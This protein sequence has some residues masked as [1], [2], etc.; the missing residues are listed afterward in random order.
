M[1]FLKDKLFSAIKAKPK[2]RDRQ[3]DIA[4]LLENFPSS[5][6]FAESYRT[7]R[8]NLFFTAIEKELK[9]V[10]V[11]SSVEGEGKTTT[12]INLAHTIAQT[13]KKVLLMDADWRRPHLSSLYGLR[14]ENGLSSIVGETYGTHLSQ[15]T[16]SDFSVNDLIQ[17]TKLQ[18]RTCCLNLKNDDTDI[19]F[20]FAKGCM[21]DIFWKN[22]S[23]DKNKRLINILIGDKL[24]TEKEANI[25]LGHLK[26]S[27][28]HL[29]TILYSMG[30]VS[31][32]D[33][34][35]ALSMY[36]I[37]AVK[38]A[39][40]METGTF[41]F[42]SQ[43]T[44]EFTKSS[45]LNV[46]FDK[47]YS[48]FT[49]ST[50]DYWGNFLKKNINEVIKPTKTPNLYLIPSGAVP[51]NPSELIGSELTGYLLNYLKHEFDFIVID[52]PPIMPATDALLMAPRTDGTVLVIK[53]GHADRKII[54]SAVEQY[55]AARQPII[56]TV[57]NRVNMKKEGYYRYYKKYYSSYYGQKPT[58]NS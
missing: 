21:S 39:S 9:S 31:Q 36:T 20:F 44:E 22:Q 58:E 17:M 37:E 57:L 48:E 27:A 35:R 30:F 51:P 3:Q 28:M 23:D 7:L 5:S 45:E 52:T 6:S 4:N 54:Q 24:L 26:N 14:N 41:E 8:T 55:H 2:Q 47:L 40:A 13:N 10:I 49:I 11:T 50:D 18:N 46:D 12:S 16:L 43:N 42:S 53:A 56:G 29:G 25:A 33:I 32:K 19:R 38:A 1:N 15:G 34:S